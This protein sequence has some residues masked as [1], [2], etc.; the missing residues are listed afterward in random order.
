MEWLTSTYLS[1]ILS[2]NSFLNSMINEI[3]D[4]ENPS[5]W[6]EPCSADPLN[7]ITAAKRQYV[8]ASYLMIKGNSSALYIS[9]VQMYGVWTICPECSAQVG[10]ALSKG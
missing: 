9:G 7:C 5:K 3:G 6:R 10:T 1:N 4:T 2:S 8:L